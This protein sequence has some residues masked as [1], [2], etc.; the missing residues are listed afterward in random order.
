MVDWCLMRMVSSLKG[1]N[2]YLR[3]HF[4]YA[5]CQTTTVYA[6]QYQSIDIIVFKKFS[7]YRFWNQGSLNAYFLHEISKIFSKNWVSLHFLVPP[8]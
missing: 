1:L 8:V 6:T 3:D 5:S 2:S 7:F 4:D